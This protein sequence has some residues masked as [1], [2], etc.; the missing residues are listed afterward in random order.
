[1][2]T[3][4]PQVITRAGLLPVFA[5][6]SAGGDEFANVLPGRR[7][8]YIKNGGVAARTL[9][10][11]AAGKKQGVGLVDVNINLPA[12]S[13]RLVGPFIGSIWNNADNVVSVEY[14]STIGLT[15]ALLEIQ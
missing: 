15:V 3:L 9:S 13:E 12:D 5:A 7:F 1:M 6:V 11:V 14:D 2:A 4:T 8:I 10:L